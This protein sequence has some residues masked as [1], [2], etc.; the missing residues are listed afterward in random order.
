LEKQK[1]AGA[2]LTAADLA[3]YLKSNAVPACPAGGIYTLHP[4]GLMPICN[5]PGHAVAK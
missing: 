1:P 5:I 3:P 2:L 4:V